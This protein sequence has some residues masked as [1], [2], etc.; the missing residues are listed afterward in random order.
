LVR[1]VRVIGTGGGDLSRVTVT[2]PGRG[3]AMR[4]YGTSTAMGADDPELAAERYVTTTDQVPALR[5]DPGI[6]RSP[7]LV[8][9]ASGSADV[10]AVA[11]RLPFV[12]VSPQVPPC[13]TTDT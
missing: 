6:R 12:A 5:S 9:D 10:W 8:V 11:R 1:H 3:D 4:S 2:S 7:Q 13:S